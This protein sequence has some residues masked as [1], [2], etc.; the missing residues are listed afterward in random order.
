MHIYPVFNSYLDYI[1]YFLVLT[2]V[3][4]AL[5]FIIVSIVSGKITHITQVIVLTGIA[6]YDSFSFFPIFMVL[7]FAIMITSAPFRVHG[8]IRRGIIANPAIIKSLQILTK[9]SQAIYGI[10]SLIILVFVVASVLRLD[11]PFIPSTSTNS[12]SKCSALFCSKTNGM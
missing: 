1:F 3:C 7:S 12:E 6:I 2:L 4:S 11:L 9:A 10:L 5:L 8:A